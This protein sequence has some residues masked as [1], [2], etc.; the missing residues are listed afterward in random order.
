MTS[1]SRTV[2]PCNTCS[3][4]FTSSALQ[5]T[6]MRQ[7][8]HIYNLKRRISHLPVLTEK[9]FGT[10]ESKAEEVTQRQRN[11]DDALI[12]KTRTRVAHNISGRDSNSKSPTGDAND[13]HSKTL[14]STRC[15]FCPSAFL[16]PAANLGH[17]STQHS[18]FIPAPS[19][20]YSLE[21]FLSYL[22]VLIF[23]YHEC[24]YCGQKKGSVDAVQT[25]MRDKGHCMIDM[26]EL[27]G[28]WDVE[29]EEGDSEDWKYKMKAETHLPS[30]LVVNPW[31]SNSG[32]ETTSRAANPS[33]ACAGRASRRYRSL[34]SANTTAD[35]SPAQQP[36]TPHLRPSHTALHHASNDPHRSL[37]TISRPERGLVG[38]SDQQIRTLQVLDKK[39]KSR[40]EIAKA[41]VR[42]ASQQQ[43]VKTVY[44][45][46]E[47]PV[48]QAG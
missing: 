10:L 35:S 23:E 45:K 48:Y 33:F 2:F 24:L 15:L 28:F 9:D 7:P 8:W 22:A 39:M 29:V 32:D 5:R 14:S 47:N 25:H 18:L 13:D 40:E 17:M 1:E 12:R 4:S 38:V 37:S 41:R 16:T 46:T 11:N 6:H 21:S 36:P 19:Q 31:R 26:S 20:L 43:P 30:G 34:R 27:R 44:Y 3:L 42:Y